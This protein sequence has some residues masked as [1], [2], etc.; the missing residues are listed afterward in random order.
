MPTARWRVAKMVKRHHPDTPIIFG[1][2]SATY[3]HE[4]L[5][6]YPFVDFVIRGDSAEEPLRQLMA[7]LKG[8]RGAPALAE[9]PNLTWRDRSGTIHVNPHS[10]RPDN[11]D[12]VML[13]YRYV[14]HACRAVIST[15]IPTCRSK[16]RSTTRS[17]PRSVV[18]GCTQS[19]V[20]CGGSA[21]TFRE[22]HGR[23]RPAFRNPE[24]AG[25]RCAA[26]RRDERRPGVHP[27]RSTP[28]GPGLRSA[29]L[30]CYPRLHRPGHR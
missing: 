16:T 18:S 23:T 28:G 24:I 9:I 26:L 5:I 14:V 8:I 20:I 25:G 7:C 30:L 4:E 17:W 15:Y 12:H 2:F 11:L 1:G 3:Y 10:Y 22:M 13:D 6:R 19:C 29:V 27:G 21:A